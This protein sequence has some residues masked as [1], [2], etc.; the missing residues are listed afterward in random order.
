ML[1]SQVLPTCQLQMGMTELNLAV[2]GIP[3]LLTYIAAEW[4]LTSILKYQKN[5]QYVILW[6]K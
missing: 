1:V 3:C 5:M 4:K 6:E 2:Y